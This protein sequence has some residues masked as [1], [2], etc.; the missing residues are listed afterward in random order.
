MNQPSGLGRLDLTDDQRGKV[1]EL[2]RAA[3][4]QAAPLADELAFA[5]RSLQRELFADKRDNGTLNSLSAKIANLEKQLRDLRLKSEASVSDVLTP[6]Q[7]ETM[8]LMVDQNGR[9]VAGAGGRGGGVGRG[10][11]RAR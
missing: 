8:R 10:Q 7:R 6:K 9:G 5:Q 3:R 1:D 4:D 11:A 2:R